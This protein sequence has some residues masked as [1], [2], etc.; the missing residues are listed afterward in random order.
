MYIIVWIPI[1]LGV[2][3]TLLVVLGVWWGVDISGCVELVEGAIAKDDIL[4]GF[5]AEKN[6]TIIVHASM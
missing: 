2:G 6:P 1:K 3:I 4:V 5:V